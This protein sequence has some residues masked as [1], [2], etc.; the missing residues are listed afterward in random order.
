MKGT[1]S[2]TGTACGVQE[3]V[4]GGT[5]EQRNKSKSKALSHGGQKNLLL[6]YETQKLTEEEKIQSV[7]FEYFPPPGFVWC[8]FLEID[9][10][11]KIER[12]DFS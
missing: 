7:L 3:L 2:G 4:T 12:R 9:P 6:N 10:L 1:F 8:R 5:W 11:V